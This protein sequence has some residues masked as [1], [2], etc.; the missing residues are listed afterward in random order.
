M[1]DLFNIIQFFKYFNFEFICKRFEF[2]IL[3]ASYV[4]NLNFS[5][6]SFS[7]WNMSSSKSKGIGGGG[8]FGGLCFFRLSR[9]CSGG[10]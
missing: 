5:R 9:N 6:L 7:V 10:S 8:G 4:N 2:L 1:I 3:P